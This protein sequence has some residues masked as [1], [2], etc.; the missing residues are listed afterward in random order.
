[1]PQE[2]I[3]VKNSKSTNSPNFSFK[4]VRCSFYE[5][6]KPIRFCSNLVETF[7]NPFPIRKCKKKLG[8]TMLVFKMALIKVS[9]ITRAIS[10][11]F[12]LL[13]LLVG[14]Q[15]TSEFAQ[16]PGQTLSLCQKWF[17]ELFFA[18]AIV[19]Q[20]KIANTIFGCLGHNG[21]TW[22]NLG[23]MYLYDFYKIFRKCLYGYIIWKNAKK[24]W[25][26]PCWLRSGRP[27]CK[28]PSKLRKIIQDTKRYGVK[29][30]NFVRT[31]KHPGKYCQCTR[32]DFE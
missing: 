17:W 2:P 10:L 25:G 21:H 23:Q 15:W 8:V 11:R 19:L 22:A 9:L 13:T 20:V 28:L 27:K 32:N 5:F 14:R 31:L 6:S 29:G 12:F 16:T 3:S 26:S 1:M 4:E 18:L 30:M 7:F 24:N